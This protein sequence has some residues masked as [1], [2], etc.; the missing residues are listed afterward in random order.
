VITGQFGFHDVG[1]R[2]LAEINDALTLTPGGRISRVGMV[3]GAI[4]WDDC[5]CGL[6]AGSVGRQYLS[7]L[8]PSQLE[9][10]ASPCAAA[11][12]VGVLTVQIIRC[13]PNM[14]EDG[15][16]PSV[17]ALDGSA[18][19]VIA[20]AWQVMSVVPCFLETLVDAN[21]IGDYLVHPVVAQGPLGG[22]VGND[23]T[24]SVALNRS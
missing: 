23:V 19:E 14:R 2:V 21:E 12:L 15:T 13:A 3:P 22:C 8:F 4:A 24:I 11:W 9:D 16:P 6:L 5:D 17:A 7:D 10:T 1:T 18:R 20:D